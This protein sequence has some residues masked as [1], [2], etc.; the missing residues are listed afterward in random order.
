MPAFHPPINKDDPG[1]QVRR[2]KA[3]ARKPGWTDDEGVPEIGSG[4]NGITKEAVPGAPGPTGGPR[5]RRTRLG[6]EMIEAALYAAGKG[7]GVVAE[8]EVPEDRARDL[9]ELL[10][11]ACRRL[12][13]RRSARARARRALEAMGCR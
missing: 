5:D 7:M 3:F 12:Y 10:S 1:R 8:G 4:L 6:F 13:G 11:S 2:L 9:L